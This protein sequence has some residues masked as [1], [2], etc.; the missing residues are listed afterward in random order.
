MLGILSGVLF[1]YAG[2]LPEIS[3]LDHY[4][5]NTITRVYSANA[6]LIGDFAVERRLVVSYDDISPFFRQALV[7]AEDAGFDTHV[8]LS[9]SAILL[10][11]TRDLFDGIEAKFSHRASR[12]AGASTLTQQL[13]RISSPKPSAIAL[14]TSASN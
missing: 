11:L 5:P 9:V 1:A 7:A 4:N 10:R 3:A 8:G 13:A 6:E 12:P 2:D 14:A